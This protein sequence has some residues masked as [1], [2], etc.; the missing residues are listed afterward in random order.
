MHIHSCTVTC[1]ALINVLHFYFVALPIRT[2]VCPVI[3][4]C[5]ALLNVQNLL[6]TAL[7]VLTV[8][9]PITLVGTQSITPRTIL[10]VRLINE[11]TYRRIIGRSSKIS[12]V[13]GLKKAIILFK[14]R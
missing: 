8:I 3:I 9:E 4:I 1:T 14:Y 12:P 10:H 13:N 11:E 6:F 5:V 2:V 7:S